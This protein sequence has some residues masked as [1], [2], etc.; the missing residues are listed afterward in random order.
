MLL[1]KREHI[2]PILSGQKSQT[3]R[4]WKKQRVKVGSIQKCYSGGLPFSRCKTCGGWGYPA[5]KEPTTYRELCVMC[6]GTGRLQPFARVKILRVWKQALAD[7]TAGDVIAEGYPTHRDYV[8]AFATIHH[9]GYE[10]KIV[11]NGAPFMVWA[12]EFELV[13]EVRDVA[14]E[15]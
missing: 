11:P 7:M 8:Q 1:F 13:P 15:N 12:V 2:E 3:R 4:L 6:K 5:V 10:D 9:I 14:I